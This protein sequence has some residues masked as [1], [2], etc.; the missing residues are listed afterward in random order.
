MAKS[1]VRVS[2]TV[3]GALATAVAL[4]FGVASY[5]FA[6][7]PS[8]GTIQECRTLA[9]R[10]AANSPWLHRGA[11]SPPVSFL[12]SDIPKLYCGIEA[13]GVLRTVYTSVTLYGVSNSDR[14]QGIISRLRQLRAEGHPRPIAVRFWEREI[15]DISTRQ[16]GEIHHHAIERE[17][18]L[19]EET[20]R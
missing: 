13:R 8:L 7:L 9:D 6:D 20:I 5:I 11:S 17:V 3:V 19:R 18:L 14:Q 10:V 16:G 2:L 15:W 1:R 12:A 4:A